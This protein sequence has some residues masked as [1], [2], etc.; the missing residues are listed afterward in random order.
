[1]YLEEIES[2]CSMLHSKQ[3]WYIL[4][5]NSY[6]YILIMEFWTLI[7]IN[8]YEAS[9]LRDTLLSSRSVC[10]M[11]SHP[12]FH[13]I[14]FFYRKGKGHGH[15]HAAGESW[16]C[17]IAEEDETKMVNQRMTGM[18]SALQT[19]I[20]VNVNPATHSCHSFHIYFISCHRLVRPG[21]F[22]TKWNVFLCA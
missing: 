21:A 15:L 22:L 16:A 1:M 10:S 2:F 8:F 9:D 13:I 5:E 12:F 17:G 11:N 7:Q 19:L 18:H 4:K 6:L 3:V 14:V 20:T